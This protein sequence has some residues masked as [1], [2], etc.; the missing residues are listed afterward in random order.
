MNIGDKWN[1]IM[2]EMDKESSKLLNAYFD[3]G[4]NFI[5]IANAYQEEL[6]IATKYSVPYK[7][8][9]PKII[10]QVNYMG[11]NAKSMHR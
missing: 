1:E 7:H 9:G 6:F 11:N 3:M 5:D 2:G 4:G 8:A 10:Q